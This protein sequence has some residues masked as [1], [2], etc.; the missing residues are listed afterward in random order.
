MKGQNLFSR[1]NKKNISVCH[2]MFYP[3]CKVIKKR[4]NNVAFL[5]NRHRCSRCTG[6]VWCKKIRLG[7]LLEIACIA[8]A[9][10]C[11]NESVY[12]RQ[13]QQI[14]VMFFFFFFY[15]ENRV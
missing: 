15:P 1:K 14:T 5:V 2:L 3:A 7:K 13:I 12:F 11:Q 9:C 6:C 8:I 10:H 4:W